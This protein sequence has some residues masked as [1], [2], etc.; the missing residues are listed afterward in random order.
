M[1]RLS[2]K[3]LLLV[4][5]ADIFE[6]A[7]V[8][9]STTTPTT[10]K[11]AVRRHSSNPGGWS[12]PVYDA[13]RVLLNQNLAIIRSLYEYEVNDLEEITYEELQNNQDFQEWKESQLTDEDRQKQ[14]EE[15]E[16]RQQEYRQQ[17]EAYQEQLMQQEM[18][19]YQ[20][21]LAWKNETIYVSNEE[22]DTS[23]SL[24]FVDSNPLLEGRQ[25]TIGSSMLLVGMVVGFGAAVVIMRH[26]NKKKAK[27]RPL[28]DDP[29]AAL[30]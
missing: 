10:T 8:V 14:Q 9:A 25:W 16:K 2:F 22:A 28:M 21:Y 4:S 7:A 5:L 13:G 15:E 27:S 23:T 30:A 20:E 12:V 1:M 24:S 18:E 3:S 11:A 6:Y 17:Q 19:A 26:K 29:K